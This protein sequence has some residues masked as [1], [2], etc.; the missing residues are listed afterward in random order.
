M[1]FY[2]SNR[3]NRSTNEKG[4]IDEEETG[5]GQKISEEEDNENG[6]KSPLNVNTTW[7]TVQL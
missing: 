1:Q 3:Y 6:G 4:Y 7:N 2:S 5:L